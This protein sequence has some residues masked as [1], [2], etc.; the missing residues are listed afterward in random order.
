MS[1]V[2]W[3]VVRDCGWLARAAWLASLQSWLS[4]GVAWQPTPIEPGGLSMGRQTGKASRSRAQGKRAPGK[5]APRRPG[6]TSRSRRS[7]QIVLGLRAVGVCVVFA[8]TAAL[9]LHAASPGRNAAPSAHIDK[10]RVQKQVATL[11]AGIPQHGAILGK[12]TAPVTMQVFVDLE[13]HG[14]GTRWFDTM[15]PA[16]L[17]K[18]VRPGVLRLAFRSF[19]TDTLNA[20]PF[21]MQQTSAMAAGSQNLLWNYADT[22]VNEQG[23]EFTN[24][25]T[26]RF[27]RGIAKQVPGL[28]LAAWERSRNA[29]MERSVVSDDSNARAD[30]FHD[31]PAFQ[32]GRTGGKMR[33]LWGSTI[34]DPHKYIVHTKPSGERYIAGVSPELQHPISL[35]DAADV[36]KATGEL[37]CRRRKGLCPTPRRQLGACTAWGSTHRPKRGQ[38]ARQCR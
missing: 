15:L 16:I 30:G 8:L 24:Y 38:R 2:F 36:Q 9:I 31:T 35:V 7:L 33:T 20:M 25:A 37:L 27:L 34:E 5:G 4:W 11:F 6:R 26:E 13:D 29:P 21:I 3:L 19:K 32:I 14:D 12:P 1:P 17:D 18:F 22:F 28:D 10:L 23:R